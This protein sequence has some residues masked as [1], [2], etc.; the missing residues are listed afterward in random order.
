LSCYWWLLRR[1]LIT[2][3]LAT[4]SPLADVQAQAGHVQGS[5]TLRYTG[6]VD[7]RSAAKQ[8]VYATANPN[9]VQDRAAALP[10]RERDRQ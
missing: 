10:G 6:A 2:E 9:F 1:T 3:L 4:G 5:T 8:D 7:A